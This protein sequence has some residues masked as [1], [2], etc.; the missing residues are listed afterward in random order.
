MGNLALELSKAWPQSCYLFLEDDSHLCESDH[1]L[2]ELCLRNKDRQDLMVFGFG[3]SGFM[4]NKV[5]E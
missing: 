5:R 3:G 2:D 1:I 4:I